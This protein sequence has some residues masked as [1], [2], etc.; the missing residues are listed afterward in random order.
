MKKGYAAFILNAIASA[1]I[2]NMLFE[3]GISRHQNR[4]YESWN[5]IKADTTFQITRLK[6]SHEFSLSYSTNPGSSTEFLDGK[7]VLDKGE[8]ILTTDST[9]YTIKTNI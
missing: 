8:F 4:L 9:K 6:E 3:E 7:Y 5:F 1:F 2:M